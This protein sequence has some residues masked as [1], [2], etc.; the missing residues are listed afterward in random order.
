MNIPIKN[1]FYLLCY[2]WNR[3]DE[4]DL[5]DVGETNPPTFV[6]LLARVFCNVAEILTRRGLFRSYVESE[7]DT[8]CPRG[9][10]LLSSTVSRALRAKAQV[11]CGIHELSIDILPNQILKAT[12]QTLIGHPDVGKI[13]RES[14]S[15]LQP[16]FQDVRDIRLSRSDFR[17]VVIHRN[18]KSYGFLMQLCG[19]VHEEIAPAE[20]KSGRTFRDFTGNDKAMAKVWE[21]FMTAFYKAHAPFSPSCV[22][23]QKRYPWVSSE[24][25]DY[26]LLQQLVPDLVFEPPEGRLVIVDAKFSIEPLSKSQ[27]STKRRLKRNDIFQIYAYIQNLSRVKNREDVTG[28]LIYAAVGESFDYQVEIHGFPVR[29]IGIDLDRPWE[30]I[31]D[32]LLELIP[33]LTQ[34]SIDCPVVH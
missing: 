11:A 12:I 33:T 31:H 13:Q 1:I 4:A 32:S 29:A 34:D 20:N 7:K 19:F 21:D 3:L 5:V 26:G 15:R 6:A 27:Y 14:L 22:Q 10:I 17:Q 25:G 9:K 8:L 23:S 16:Y 24:V 28:A 30:H 2:A 18:N